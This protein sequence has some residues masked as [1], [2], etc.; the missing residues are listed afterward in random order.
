[1]CK[2]TWLS[3]VTQRTNWWHTLWLERESE[4]KQNW[5]Q[6]RTDL[7]RSAP[8]CPFYSKLKQIGQVIPVLTLLMHWCRIAHETKCICICS[9]LL[10]SWQQI[11]AYIFIM[12]ISIIFLAENAL[13][14]FIPSGKCAWDLF[15]LIKSRNFI[16]MQFIHLFF[17]SICRHEVFSFIFNELRP[18]NYLFI[19]GLK[20]SLLT[21]VNFLK[22]I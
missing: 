21:I 12:K 10:S 18:F 15:K 4:R 9:L 22:T 5:R 20:V 13:F 2:F 7:S 17:F 19:K 1:M 6:N 16:Q 8:F 14:K 3:F 11:F